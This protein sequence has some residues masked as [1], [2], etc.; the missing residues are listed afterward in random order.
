MNAD[1]CRSVR[2]YAC[3]IGDGESTVFPIVH[4]L[5][6][7]SPIVNIIDQEG[8]EVLATIEVL[9]AHTLTIRPGSAVAQRPRYW[10]IGPWRIRR[11]FA[12]ELY[13]IP[14]VPPAP[15]SLAVVVCG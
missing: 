5:N 15:Q 6:T 12:K 1:P 10:K 13:V 11:P 2:K 9:G 3:M 4:N 7:W 14:P 8:R